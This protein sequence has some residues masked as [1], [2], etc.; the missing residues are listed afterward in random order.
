MSTMWEL[1]PQDKRGTF[2][3]RTYLP[4]FVLPLHVTSRINRSPESPT[5]EPETQTEYRHLEAKMQVSIR[6]K[7]VEGLLL[8][9]ADLWFAYTQRALW[10]VWRPQAS[11][12]FRSTDY[13]PE[14]IYVVPIPESM[15][16]LPGGW[17]WQI[18]QFGLAH[19]SNGQSEPLSRSWNRVYAGIGIERGEVGLQVRGNRRINE[20]HDDDDNP[21]L[22]RYIGSTE[23]QATWLPGRATTALT[24]RTNL[25]SW[26][27]GSVQ[28]DWTY[29]VD[30]DDPDGLRWYAQL[31]SGFGETLLDYNFR[32]TT[33]GVGVTLFQF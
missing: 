31:F 16:L 25:R 33:F 10:Q 13:Q 11:S 12:P 6:T 7:V 15:G 21:D 18:A 9:G 23:V 4:N 26:N 30:K 1:R 22:T 3:V 32:Q 2:I 8:P 19:Q 24:W 29:P 27:R 17:R 28:L 5:R 20:S 14:A